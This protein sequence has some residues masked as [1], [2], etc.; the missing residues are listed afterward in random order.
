MGQVESGRV[1]VAVTSVWVPRFVQRVTKHLPT[2]WYLQVLAQRHTDSDHADSRH[3]DTYHI[4]LYGE[5]S[6]NF[7]NSNDC[8]VAIATIL[9]SFLPYHRQEFC[10]SFEI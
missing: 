5:R 2:Q 7:D 6:V 3:A 1:S 10:V 4:D 9:F 8:N